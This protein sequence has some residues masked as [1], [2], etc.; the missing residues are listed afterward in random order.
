MYGKARSHRSI[1]GMNWSSAK[2]PLAVK[3]TLLFL[4]FLP[5]FINLTA[6]PVLGQTYRVIYDFTNGADGWFPAT[7]LTIDAAGNL[8][9]TT[10]LGGLYGNGAVFKL[11]HFGSRWVFTLP[12]GFPDGYDGASP[13][14]RVAIAQNGSLYGTAYLG[15]ISG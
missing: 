4:I 10:A 8:Y 7:G 3:L 6:Q 11:T 15:G 2:A 1:F 5:W 9:G 12:Y 13:N 14:G